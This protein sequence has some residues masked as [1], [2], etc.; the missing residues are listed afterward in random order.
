MNRIKYVLPLWAVLFMFAAC[1]NTNLIDTN[2]A[3]PDNNWTYAK[4]AK[5]AFEVKDST[6]TYAVYFKL[7]HTTD[8]RYSNLFVILH[9]KGESV[10]KNTRYQFKL[11][12][13]DGQ[14]LG[15]GSGDLY[16]YNFPLLQN[17]Q[18]AKPGKYEIEIEQNM[19]DNPLTGIS[20][21][22]IT[23]SNTAQKK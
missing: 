19:R 11:A 5:A 20:D 22:G 21:I 14:W 10:Q 18:F 3:I 6:Q 7:R 17:Y 2:T 16:T 8:Y 13:A 23:V 12:K 15:K 9:V 1:T 4:T